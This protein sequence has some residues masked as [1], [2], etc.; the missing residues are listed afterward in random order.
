VRC[1]KCKG[2]DAVR[3]TRENGPTPVCSRHPW[4]S[5]DANL[6]ALPEAPG[7]HSCSISASAGASTVHST[8]ARS[9]VA[10]WFRSSLLPCCWEPW[11]HTPTLLSYI[12]LYLVAV[13]IRFLW[14]CLGS[15]L[16]SCNLIVCA[17]FVCWLSNV[18]PVPSLVQ[19]CLVWTIP[20][21]NLPEVTLPNVIVSQC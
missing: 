21:F 6:S 7:L 16:Y 20:K 17:R 19:G 5:V 1:P 12:C 11:T 10:S 4:F 3:H 18:L 14:Q 13:C 15:L 2:T 8:M 9:Y